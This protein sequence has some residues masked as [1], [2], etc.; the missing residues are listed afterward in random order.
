MLAEPKHKQRFLNLCV[1]LTQR[2]HTLRSFISTLRAHRD[3]LRPQLTAEQRQLADEI[4][5]VLHSAAQIMAGQGSVDDTPMSLPEA[6]VEIEAS[7]EQWLIQ[8]ELVFIASQANELL[9]LS[10]LLL[11]LQLATRQ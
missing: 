11:P 4:G 7:A 3:R 1:A 8:Q 10:W 5:R 9:R 2:S 6:C